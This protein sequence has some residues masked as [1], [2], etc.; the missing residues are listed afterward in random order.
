M[1]TFDRYQEE[2]RT[3]RLPTADE[4]YVLMNIVAELGEF[5]GHLAK[6]TRD[7]TKIEPAVLLKE[8]GD[9]LWHISALCD[10]MGVELSDVAEMN[11]DKLESRHIRGKITGSG[12]ER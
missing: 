6:A 5:F 2:A 11:L 7:E 10:D 4:N 1:M 9:M 8:L 3:F 12:D